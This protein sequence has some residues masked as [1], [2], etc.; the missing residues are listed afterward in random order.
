MKLVFDYSPKCNQFNYLERQVCYFFRQLIPKTSNYCPKNRALG[1]PGTWTIRK[2][3]TV[4]HSGFLLPTYFGRYC[5]SM[6]FPP[7]VTQLGGWKGHHKVFHGFSKISWGNFWANHAII[8]VWN[9]DLALPFRGP[10]LWVLIVLG[11]D[12]KSLTMANFCVRQQFLDR[13]ITSSL[14]TFKSKLASPAS[15]SN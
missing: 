2:K 13:K 12:C 1:F 14:S 4:N 8:V 6:L 15:L 5:F 10:Y 3:L 11:R 7:I 9:H